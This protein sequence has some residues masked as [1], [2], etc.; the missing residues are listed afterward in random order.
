MR[1]TNRPAVRAAAV[2][3]RAAAGVV[4]AATCAAPLAAQPRGTGWAGMRPGQ[5]AEMDVVCSGTW[6]PVTVVSVAPAEG[7]PATDYVVRRPDGSEV[8]FR[9]PDMY[10]PCGRPA[11]AAARERAAFPAPAAG[12]YQCQSPRGPE[13]VFDF[14]LLDGRTYRDRDGGRGA[15]RLDPSTGDLV[16]ATGPLGGRRVQRLSAATFRVLRSDGAQTGVTCP[17]NAARDPNARRL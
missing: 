17:R 8:R 16:F 10:P 2:S 6:E 7:R 9:V 11:G 1:L 13:P 5:P 4:A 3:L 12:V 14:A 15:Y